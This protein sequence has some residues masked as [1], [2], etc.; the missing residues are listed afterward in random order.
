MVIATIGVI[1]M[2][3]RL[4]PKSRAEVVRMRKQEAI[5]SID[6][7]GV[8]ALSLGFCAIVLAAIAY[9]MGGDNIGASVILSGAAGI[10]GLI[11]SFGAETEDNSEQRK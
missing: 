3:I 2:P 5:Q 10:I 6:W 9:F 7:L 1:A 4:P 11:V 8:W